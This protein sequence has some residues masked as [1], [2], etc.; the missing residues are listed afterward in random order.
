METAI[1]KTDSLSLMKN[2]RGED[3]RDEEIIVSW[4]YRQNNLHTRL[5]NLICTL[6]TDN[7]KRAQLGFPDHVR[8]Y[9]RYRHE[10]GWWETVQTRRGL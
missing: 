3:A 2:E 6:D 7:L 4:Q 1:N 10:S 8:A 5:L 9:N